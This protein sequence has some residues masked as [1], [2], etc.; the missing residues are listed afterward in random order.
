MSAL[1]AFLHHLAAFA[2]VAALVVEMMLLKDPLDFKAVRRLQLVDRVYGLS[3]AVLL[4]VGLLRVFYFEKG[5]GYYFQSAPF[6]GKLALFVFV[7][8]LSVYPTVKVLSW[9]A[10]INQGRVPDVNA[11]TLRKMRAIVHL[12]LGGVVFILL[13]AALMARGIGSLGLP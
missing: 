1:F 7:G 3:A 8:L 5:T 10:S 11:G 13:F 12:E 9:R 2:L 6:I 4:L